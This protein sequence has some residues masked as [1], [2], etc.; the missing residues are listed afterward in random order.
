MGGV[1]G[2][3]CCQLGGPFRGIGAH[4]AAGLIIGLIS[5]SGLSLSRAQAPA[6]SPLLT[7]CP[8]PGFDSVANLDLAAY[9]SAPW[10]VL[11][12]VRGLP[13]NRE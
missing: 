2:R 1:R 12:Q 3:R 9:V 8:P 5:L 4:M 11:R 6:E 13:E 10:F 7:R